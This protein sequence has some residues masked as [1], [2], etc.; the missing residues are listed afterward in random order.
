MKE[1]LISGAVRTPIGGLGGTLSKVSAVELGKITAKESL[2]RSGIQPES[3][4]EVV[5][6]NVLQAG[7][8]QNPARQIAIGCEVPVEVPSFTVNQVQMSEPL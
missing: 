8:G 4:D 3:I 5:I 1:I 6:G 7:L 2:K